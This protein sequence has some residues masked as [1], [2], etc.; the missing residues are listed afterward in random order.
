MIQ[1]LTGSLTEDSKSSSQSKPQGQ[2]QDTVNTELFKRLKESN[3]K[4]R[5]CQALIEIGCFEKG[6][7]ILT[8]FPKMST[9]HSGISTSLSR[10]LNAHINQL[11]FE[12]SPRRKVNISFSNKF[13]RQK[14][15]EP[16][17]SYETDVLSDFQ[18]SSKSEFKFFYSQWRSEVIE[19]LT[20]DQF[21]AIT[22]RL[23]SFIG[24]LLIR[25]AC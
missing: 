8:L 4:A 19:C 15:A 17:N 21:M 5:L 2:T 1:K 11:Y 24:I 3:Q 23:L 12:L 22:N 13:A 18:K 14:F 25:I 10:I 6:I 16:L 20:Y 7:K 9:I